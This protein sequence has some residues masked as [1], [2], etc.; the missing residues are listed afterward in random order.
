QLP[1]ELT[2]NALPFRIEPQLSDFASK[3]NHSVIRILSLGGKVLAQS[4]ASAPSLGS[5]QLTART[6]HGYRVLS[7][8]AAV[9]QNGERVGEVIIEYGK[10]ISDTEATVRRV[11]LFLLL[12]VLFGT[13]FALL[14]G[15]A[16]ARRAMAPIARLTSTAAEIART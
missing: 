16:I 2:I 6:I 13:I 7:R 10:R 5:P 15:M 9:T 14:A 1:N 4:P 11:E 12:G 8:A 3:E